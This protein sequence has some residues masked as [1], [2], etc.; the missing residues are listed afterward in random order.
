[1]QKAM[2]ETERR[3]VMQ[4]AHNKA[5]GIVPVG[6]VKSVED[7]LEATYAPGGAPGL[8]RKIADS[9]GAYHVTREDLSPKA[10]AKKLKVLE[11]VMM[12]HAKNLEFEDAARVRDEMAVLK[13]QALMS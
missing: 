3:R 7:I 2:D 12:Q 6:V 11:E 8:R 1:M 10:M 13:D 5:N 4:E 9:H